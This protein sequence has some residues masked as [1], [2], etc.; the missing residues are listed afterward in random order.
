MMH[1]ESRIDSSSYHLA[2]FMMIIVLFSI[3]LSCDSVTKE[4]TDT[5]TITN[6]KWM[7]S[8]GDEAI[9]SWQK[10]ELDVV[11]GKLNGHELT[12]E[13]NLMK[14]DIAVGTAVNNPVI[15]LAQERSLIDCSSLG[16]DDFI[17]KSISLD[18][19]KMMVIAG[20]SE[21]SASYGVFELLERLGFRFLVTGDIYPEDTDLKIP[22]LDETVT[23]TQPWRGFFIAQCITTT[24][25]MS[26]EDYEQLFDQMVKMRLNKVLFY[27]FDSDPYIDYSYNGERKL[28]GD[29]SDPNSG[30]ISYGRFHGSYLTEDIEVGRE[31]FGD[32]KRI[33]PKEMQHVSSSDEA[34]DTAKAFMQE[35]M[36]AAKQ[37]EIGVWISFLPQ[38]ISP[39]MSKYTRRM[40]RKHDHWSYW[41]SCTDPVADEINRARIKNIIE[42]YPDLEGISLGIPEGFFDDPYPDSRKLVADRWDDYSG[43]L[44][45][46]NKYWGKYWPTKERQEAHIRADIG[47]TEILL[48]TIKSC[49]E[50][51][52]DM[53]LA[54]ATVCKAYLLT[55]LHDQ[56]EKDIAFIDIESRSLWTVDGAPLHLFGRMKDRDCAIIPRAVDDGSLA[57]MQF[58]LKLYDKDGFIRSGRE[59]GTKGFIIQ[60]THIAGNEHNVDYLRRGLW[61]PDITVEQ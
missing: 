22:H 39:N 37:R 24:S 36:R 6:A 40:S 49:K 3:F 18:G 20:G 46:Q 31:K 19:K 21:T 14:V 13:K 33:A 43:A 30:Y 54:V 9:V 59:H 32:R 58:N 44:E 35:I 27:S 51:K 25:M 15:R 2:V 4:N 56:L 53:P 1:R 34:L 42:S 5:V 57:G 10:K 52:P 28:V 41:V 7:F 38:F 12:T 48:K 50:L 55:K 8:E 17:L 47:F 23:C 11:L 45:I 26:L 29:I 60:L 61:N 16:E